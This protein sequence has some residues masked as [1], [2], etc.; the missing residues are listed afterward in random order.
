MDQTEITHRKDKHHCVAGLRLDCI[1]L[2]GTRE[3][4]ADGV[5]LLNLKPFKLQT[6]QTVILTPTLSVLRNI[7]H[8]AYTL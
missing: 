6:R 4:I 2:Y 5:N 3:Y 7:I 8:F 1:V